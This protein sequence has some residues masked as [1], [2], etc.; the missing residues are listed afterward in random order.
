LAE[1]DYVTAIRQA[2]VPVEVKAGVKG[3]MKSLWLF[4][5]EKHLSQAVRCSFENFGAFNFTDSEDNDAMRH[6]TICPIYAIARMRD[7]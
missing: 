2:V 3:G 4:M 1:V 7:L 6:V 5:R